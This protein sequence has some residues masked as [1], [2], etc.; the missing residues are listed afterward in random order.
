MKTFSG[1]LLLFIVKINFLNNFQNE[2]FSMVL[3]GTR[4]NI[5]ERVN[6]QTLTEPSLI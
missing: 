3:A 4:M 1:A 2:L 6:W 5:I